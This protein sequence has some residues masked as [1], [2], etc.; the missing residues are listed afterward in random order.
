LKGD[1]YPGV[2]GKSKVVL[3]IVHKESRW[4]RG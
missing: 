4:N 3:C 2:K 1:W